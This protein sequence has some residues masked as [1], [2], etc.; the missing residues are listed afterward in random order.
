MSAISLDGRVVK[1]KVDA[2]SATY[3]EPPRRRRECDERR[4]QS[5]RRG[6]ASGPQPGPGHAADGVEYSQT[7]SAWTN[8]L[9]GRSDIE[10]RQ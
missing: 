3:E 4:S 7:G 5:G 10:V 8:G 9:G 2:L 6:A 1:W